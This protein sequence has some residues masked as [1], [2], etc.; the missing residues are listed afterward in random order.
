MMPHE[1]FPAGTGP[2]P[3]SPHERYV[4]D[5]LAEVGRWGTTTLAERV[6]EH[7][8][9]NPDGLAFIA[10][11]DRL[12]WRAFDERSDRL[13]GHL[14]A[15]GLARGERMGVLLPDGVEVHLAYLAALKA[16][17]IVVGLG[18]RAGRQELRHLLTVAG[19]TALLSLDEHRGEP[20]DDLVDGLG[21]RRL[22]LV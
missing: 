13:A 19:A 9:T 15:S 4:A 17:V 20:V 14:V 7:A 12:T 5:R 10:G 18:P 8:R 2:E 1:L 21:L 11:E 22:S 6:R 3:G 16:G